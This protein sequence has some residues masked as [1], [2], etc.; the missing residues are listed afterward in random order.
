M[1]YLVCGLVFL[2]PPVCSVWETQCV[3]QQSIV[4]ERPASL[5]AG[6]P[7]VQQV[8]V[9]RRPLRSWEQSPVS[10]VRTLDQWD[11]ETT[12]RSLHATPLWTQDVHSNGGEQWR[13]FHRAGVVL[14]HRVIFF[15]SR[16]LGVVI[17]DRVQIEDIKIN[18]HHKFLV[19]VFNWLDD[20]YLWFMAESTKQ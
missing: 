20:I 14:G 12:Q 13:I 6:A 10:P 15:L 16:D 2:N 5:S 19:W 1:N 11:S 9:A 3:G 4:L 17:I 7:R 8:S 18:R